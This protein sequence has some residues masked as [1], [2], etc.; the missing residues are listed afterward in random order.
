MAQIIHLKFKAVAERR[1]RYS[2]ISKPRRRTCIQLWHRSILDDK[3]FLILYLPLLQRLPVLRPPPPGR[4]LWEGGLEASE[5]TTLGPLFVQTL[6]LQ[7]MAATI[8]CTPPNN[9]R[10]GLYHC[11]TNSFCSERFLA[12]RSSSS[13]LSAS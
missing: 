3:S 9:P 5:E 11:G 7:W 4:M 13:S 2:V 6:L 8:H 1:L 12:Q 10:T